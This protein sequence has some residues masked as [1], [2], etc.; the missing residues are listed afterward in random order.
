MKKSNLKPLFPI[1]FKDGN[2]RDVQTKKV[3]L[4]L[5]L[6]FAIIS[7]WRGAWGLMDI[8]LFPGNHLLSVI[9]SLILGVIILYST[10]SLLDRLV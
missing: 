8:Y 10:E 2:K 4:T 1:Y 7:F 3:F 5:L 9:I 6:A